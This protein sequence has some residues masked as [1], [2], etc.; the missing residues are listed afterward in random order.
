M[1]LCAHCADPLY[2]STRQFSKHLIAHR[3][4]HRLS[5]YDT[6]PRH[7]PRVCALIAQFLVRYTV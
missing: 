1:K 4:V 2:L 3:F 5:P 7:L 6:L